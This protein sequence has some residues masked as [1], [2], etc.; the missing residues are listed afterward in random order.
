[1]TKKIIKGATLKP[2]TPLHIRILH[3]RQ[4]NL[5]NVGV[6]LISAAKAKAL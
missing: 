6:A 4:T 5:G 3:S 1:M 2:G